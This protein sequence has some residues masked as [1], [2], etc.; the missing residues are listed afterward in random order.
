MKRRNIYVVGGHAYREYPNWMEATAIVSDM[1]KA[2]LVIFAGGSDVSTELYD[3]PEHPTTCSDPERDE[4]EVAEFE[5]ALAA[6]LPMIGTCRG[7]Q[8][9]CVMAGG[10]LVQHSRH[11][12]MH[13]ISTYD[14]Q[15]ITVTSTHHQQAYIYGMPAGHAKLLG[16][17]NG[18]SPFHF[19]GR[20]EEMVK[21]VVEGEKEC[22][23]VY[24]PKINALGIQSHPEF[25][26]HDPDHAP[27]ITYMRSLL[28][29]LME[30]TL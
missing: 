14:G 6:G 25:V 16:W 9:L 29:K 19:G 17:A 26:T 30:G 12:G 13:P 11:P 21:G 23:I 28:D 10:K 20:G 22:E 27:M 24:Y 8:F 1:G 18:L 3:Q 4:R 7:S 15:T 2:D 5:K